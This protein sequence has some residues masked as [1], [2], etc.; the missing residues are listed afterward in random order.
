[1][2]ALVR[3]LGNLSILTVLLLLPIAWVHSHGFLSEPVVQMWA[4]AIVQ[5]DGPDLFQSSESFY[6]PLPYLMS[7]LVHHLPI[8]GAAPPPHLLAASVAA[9]TLLLWGADIRD[10]H[11]TGPLATGFLVIL[12]ASNPVFL[13]A[14]SEGPGEILLLLGT[15]IFAR[16]LINLRLTGAAP[17]MMKVALGLLIV[18][19]SDRYGL[20]LV[21]GAIPFIAVAARPSM[22]TGS[23]FGYLTAMLFPAA[24][25]IGSLVFVSHIFDTPFFTPEVRIVREPL[26]LVD[27]VLV[28]LV[29]PVVP[30]AIV[31]LWS[32]K[33]YAMPL[34]AGAGTMLSGCLLVLLLGLDRE[35]A[36]AATLM[37][38]IAATAIRFWPGGARPSPVLA[39]LLLMGWAGGALAVLSA[40]SMQSKAWSE[41]ALG[42]QA[43]DIHASDRTAARFLA[44][45]TEIM[46]DVASHSGLVAALANVDNLVMQGEPLYDYAF[47]GAGPLTE[48]IAVHSDRDESASPD[49]ILQR[50]PQLSSGT[51]P[52]YRLVFDTDG[53][54]IFHR[55]SEPM[56]SP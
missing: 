7:M 52:G 46:V 49:R 41:A 39:G 34:M 17:D 15:W 12:L 22:I 35:G 18:A 16:G 45:R 37:L 26:E 28:L 47:Y 11:D 2:N 40:D 29:A 48:Y 8:P 24:A 3:P 54:R 20:F 9:L 44:G 56:R 23:S 27:L 38:A 21:V 14:L 55:T 5:V 19:I 43:S 1:M 6:P 53:W 25:A 4:R 51:L 31:R 10:N 33:Q 42:R 13:R 50:F 36:L 32:V 30:V